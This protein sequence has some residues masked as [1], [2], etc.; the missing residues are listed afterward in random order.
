MT[1]GR[2]DTQRMRVNEIPTSRQWSKNYKMFNI[3]KKPGRYNE[4][5]AYKIYIRM[6]IANE[7]TYTENQSAHQSESVQ[8]VCCRRAGCYIIRL[9]WGVRF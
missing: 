2:C 6:Q 9:F 7:I 8:C 3:D 5:M 4:T 1:M